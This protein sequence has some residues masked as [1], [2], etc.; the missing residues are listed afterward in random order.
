M[1]SNEPEDLKRCFEVQARFAR[2]MGHPTRLHIL[3]L[4]NAAKAP[5]RT[6]HLMDETG[7]T[8]GAL[9]QHLSKMASVGLIK[10]QR[11]GRYLLISLAHEEIGKACELVRQVLQ[12]QAK[13]R[14]RLLNPQEEAH[15]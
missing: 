12:D 3:H 5:V 15:A 2:V 13:E 10:T 14:S 9:S 7:I 11:S 1:I 8:K 4:L 6:Q